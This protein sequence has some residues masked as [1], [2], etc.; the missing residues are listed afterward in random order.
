[1]NSLCSDVKVVCLF[2]ISR[3]GSNYLANV[4]RNLPE[5]DV[6]AEIFHP[7]QAFS[8]SEETCRFINDRHKT[9]ARDLSKPD[10][11]EFSSW[12]R[13]HP[14][15][16]VLALVDFARLAGKK[17]VYLKI[18]ND[19]LI[20]VKEGLEALATIPGFTPV[21]LQRRCVDSFISFR[22]AKITK[23]YVQN[24]TTGVKP[25]L[26]V[27]QYMRWRQPRLDWYSLVYSVMSKK[28]LKVHQVTYEDDID[29]G[30]EACAIHWRDLLK[31]WV[32]AAEHES[33]LNT[34][35]GF[36]ATL[37]DEQSL[38]GRQDD[39]ATEDKIANWDEFYEALKNAGLAREA[40]SYLSFK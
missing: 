27:D 10:D 38:I 17:A 29:I 13:S 34:D 5:V 18:F 40:M 32:G 22:K 14:K 20:G 15:E 11:A 8:V 39:S 3:T 37:V 30:N 7:E 36:D 21:I 2:S 31:S 33:E 16:T 26:N 23:S 4:L 1:M 28:G 24:R 9:G 35:A 12:I 19:H 6:Y 25:A